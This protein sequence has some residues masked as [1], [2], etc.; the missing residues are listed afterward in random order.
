MR[1]PSRQGFPI[2]IKRTPTGEDGLG[3]LLDM[4]IEKASLAGDIGHA[5]SIHQA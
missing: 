1:G 3:S 2:L 4:S 5:Q